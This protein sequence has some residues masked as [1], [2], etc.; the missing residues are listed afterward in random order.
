MYSALTTT[1]LTSISGTGTGTIVSTITSESVSRQISP[2]LTSTRSVVISGTE[3]AARVTTTVFAA[4]GGG[5]TGGQIG[6]IVAGV[7]V[8]FLLLVAGGWLI[9]R[10]LVRIS[11]FMDRFDTSRKSDTKEGLGDDRGAVVT[12]VDGGNVRTGHELTELSP[13]ERPQMLEEWGRHGSRGPELSGSYEAHGVSE[14]DSGSV[15]RS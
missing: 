12:E 10:H 5:L 14:L 15:M 4:S 2:S 6:G 9:M 7:V 8:G 13:Q 11:R 3:T 1:T